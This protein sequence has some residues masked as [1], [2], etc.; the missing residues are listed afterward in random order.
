MF[1]LYIHTRIAEK[2]LLS[3]E[4]ESAQLGEI[5]FPNWEIIFSQ[6]SAVCL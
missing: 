5:F 2:R 1:I 6:L 3:W 4:N